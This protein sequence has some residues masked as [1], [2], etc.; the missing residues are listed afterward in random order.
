VVRPSSSS[1]PR[2]LLSAS[3]RAAPFL[4]TSRLLIGFQQSRPLLPDLHLGPASDPE[5]PECFSFPSAFQ[6]KR[7]QGRPKPPDLHLVTSADITLVSDRQTA[8]RLVPFPTCR[9]P[10]SPQTGLRFQTYRSRPPQSV[11][12]LQIPTSPVCFRPTDPDLPSLFQTYR[13]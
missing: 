9:F 6:S 7:R 8:D 4:P 13:S 1:R 2:A 3:A 11:S 5:Y 10:L 12:D